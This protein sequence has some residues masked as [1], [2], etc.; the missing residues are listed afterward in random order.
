[1]SYFHEADKS[2]KG[3]IKSQHTFNLKNKSREGLFLKQA[4][5]MVHNLGND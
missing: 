1:M 2:L 5:T 3:Y 4:E